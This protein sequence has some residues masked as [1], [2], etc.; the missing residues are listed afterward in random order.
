MVGVYGVQACAYTCVRRRAVKTRHWRMSVCP[1]AHTHT[2]TQIDSTPHHVQYLPLDTHMLIQHQGCQHMCILG[3][4]RHRPLFHHATCSHG[5]GAR[6]GC[7]GLGRPHRQQGGPLRPPLLRP[8]SLLCARWLRGPSLDGR[9]PHRHPPTRGRQ[10]QFQ[11]PLLQHLL[12]C[13]LLLKGNHR[14]LV[15]RCLQ[16]CC[17]CNGPLDGPWRGCRSGVGHGAGQCVDQ[18]LCGGGGGGGGHPL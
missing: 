2:H 13:L 11:P 12:Q 4:C 14:Q 5:R 17:F 10:R 16:F 15:S 7:W 1:Q 18:C 6:R 3:P 9:Q 8:P